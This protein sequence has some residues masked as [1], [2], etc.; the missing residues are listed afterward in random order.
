MPV[1]R[2]RGRP[3]KSDYPKIAT[4]SDE[5]TDLSIITSAVDQV[6]TKHTVSGTNNDALKTA[7]LHEDDEDFV[8]EEYDDIVVELEDADKDGT[9]SKP[10]KKKQAKRI[11]I[12]EKVSRSG[13]PSSTLERKG[14]VIRAL[15]DLSSARDKI[16]RIYG[17]NQN[18]LLKLAKV[19]EGFETCVFCFPSKTIQKDS[20]YYIQSKP[21]CAL[22]NVYDTL[23]GQSKPKYHEIAESEL[24]QIFKSEGK[25]LRIVINQAEAA[26]KTGQKT[27]FPVF[28]YGDRKGFVYNSGGL[29]TDMA[30]LYQERHEAQYL[31]ISLSQYLDKPSDRNLRMFDTEE[32]VSCIQIFELNPKTLQFTK[33]KT[34]VHKFGETWNLK[35]HEGCQNPRSLGTLAFVCQ[36]GSV[37]LLE[38][39]I[40]KEH[41][42]ELF[43]TPSLCVAMPKTAISCFDFLS[44]T[45][46]VCGFKNGYVA[47]FD[48]R[49][50]NL[51]SYY[52]KMH[53]SYI[54]SIVAA[55]SEF[56]NIVVAT[57]SVD[58]YFYLFDPKDILTTKTTVTRFRGTNLI[59]ISYIPQ[60]Y[61]LI[62]S[63]GAN[64]L[65]TVV[66]RAAFAIHS[67]S[68]Q[69]TS[70]MSI[71][72]SRAHPMSLSGSSDG[73]VVIDN[74]CRR[75]LTGIKNSSTTHTSL[76]LWKWEYNKSEDKYR[77]NHVYETYKLNVNEISGVRVDPHGVNISC[78]KWNETAICG[79]FY[80]F[81]NTAGLLTIEK[82]EN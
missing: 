11:K 69:E 18:K 63:D 78:V 20:P 40:T 70:I 35:W 41:T 66:P 12:K 13:T 52:R 28:P 54:I 59:P 50:P 48:L 82:L 72:T 21:P 14:R 27:E 39:T 81:A 6:T 3:R 80:A 36:D 34:L 23:I 44:P 56:E 42:I 64:T 9:I 45:T 25:E 73:N 7:V 33:I 16:E 58:G 30:W 67:V 53:D 49:D 5:N 61:A 43:D 57:V 76:R 75:L 29:I 71:G 17:L 47:E 79:Q 74:V 55:Y 77:L 26:L 4:A 68:L 38:V 19:K 32:H 31:A 46:I 62:H 10:K 2:P 15:K 37:K 24:D 1:K 51:P 60:L 8:P 65:K 22:E